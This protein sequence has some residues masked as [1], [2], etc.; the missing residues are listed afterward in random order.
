MPWIHNAL[1]LPLA[2]PERHRGLSRRL[3]ELE[4]FDSW[5]RDRQLKVQED[6]VKRLLDHAYRTT[7]YYRR[8]FD[9]A[10]FQ[11]S[12]WKSGQPIPVPVLTRDLLRSNVER[13]RSRA[14]PLEML[15]SATTGGTTSAPVPIWRDI[16]GLR[17]KTALQ[18]HLNRLSGF[19]QGTKVLKIWGAERDLTMNPSWKWKLY[20]KGLLRSFNAGAGELSQEVFKSFADKLNH[21]RPRIIYGY[22]ATISLFA[23]YLR[24]QGKPFHKPSRL[25][26]TAEPITQQDRERMQRIFEC[27]VTEHYGSRD[28]G[29]VAAQCDQGEQIHFHPAACYLELVYAGKTADGPMYQLFVTD[30]LNWGMPMVRYD[31]ADCVLLADAPC[32]CGSWFPSVKT[33]LGRTA[34]NFLLSDGRMVTGISVI[35]AVARIR[36]GFRHVRQIQLVQKDLDHFHVRYVADGDPD[37]T[38]KELGRFRSEVQ[39]QFRMEVQWTSERVPEI[40]RERSGKLRFCI[41]ELSTSKARMAG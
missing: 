19:D 9:G 11:P 31:T 23:E 14:F 39:K 10:G 6:K 26:V 7:P 33:I 22:G 28:I 25:I 32:P 24:E 38:Q 5:S 16:E 41:S 35:A 18:Y 40:R 29:M 36:E 1:I 17:N 12:N 8:L 20:E 3:R 34:D 21:H 30:L 2:E 15:R 13:L 27:P 4:Q 37:A